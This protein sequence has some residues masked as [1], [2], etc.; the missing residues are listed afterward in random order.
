MAAAYTARLAW[1]AV[2]QYQEKALLK[3]AFAGHVSPTV[4]RAILKG[5]VQPDGD[6]EKCLGT[7]MFS[8]IRGFTTRSE[9]STPESMI[10]LLNR[11]YAEATAAIHGHGGAIDKFIG[12]GLMATFGVLQP[13]WRQ[14]R[15]CWFGSSD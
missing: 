12:D 9:N 5:K 10:W 3:S 4:M 7:V 1:D 13:L 6:G 8:D 11:Y 15:I 2:R 14:H